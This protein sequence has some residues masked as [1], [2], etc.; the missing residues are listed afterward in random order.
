VV[1]RCQEI[2]SLLK[3]AKVR[4]HFDN[5][6]HYTPGYKFNHWELR[7]VPLR[8]NIGPRDVAGNVVEIA[9]R[10]TMEKIRGVNMAS[11]VN[12]VSGLLTAVQ[13]NIFDKAIAFRK[14]N[15]V[16]VSSYAEFKQVLEKGNVFIECHWDG[17]NEDE[18]KIKDETKATIRAIPFNFEPV[19]GKCFYTGKP[20]T[21][22][23]VFARSY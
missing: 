14:T 9:R 21:R 6:D 7:G 13:K 15:T 4:V 2:E 23:V 1:A 20:T 18:G 10:D 17:T 22:R 8:L 11:L 3:E 19:E 5:R 16:K 12:E